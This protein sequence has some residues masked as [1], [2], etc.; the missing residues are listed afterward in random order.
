MAEPYPPLSLRDISPARGE[1]GARSLKSQRI[2]EVTGLVSIS[3]ERVT[4]PPCGGDV[5]AADREGG[6]DAETAC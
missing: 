5:G 2:L 3:L 4:L 6:H 1:S